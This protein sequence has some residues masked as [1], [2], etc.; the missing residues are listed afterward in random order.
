LGRGG[1]IHRGESDLTIVW[2]DPFPP[3][4]EDGCNETALTVN[5]PNLRYRQVL[6][7][8]FRV[9]RSLGPA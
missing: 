1:Q 6:E 7:Q 5:L 4:V 9:A 3:P 2:P 8:A